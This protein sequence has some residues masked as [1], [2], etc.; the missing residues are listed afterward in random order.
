M[1]R[2]LLSATCWMCEYHRARA[3]PAPLGAPPNPCLRGGIGLR[4]PAMPGG[5]MPPGGGVLRGEDTKAGSGSQPAPARRLRSGP[6]TQDYSLSGFVWSSVSLSPEHLGHGVS[7]KVTVV[8][9]SLRE[10]LTFTCDCECPSGGLRG[11]DQPQTMPGGGIFGEF[12]RGTWGSP[13]LAVPAGSSTVDL[14]IYQTLCYTHDEL[15]AVDVE[16]FV[17]KLCGLEEFLQK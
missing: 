4:A 2:W 5:E 10:P 13:P 9:D 15:H 8:C 12:S 11:R 6:S 3:V 7:L 14:L 16:E 1:R 17:L